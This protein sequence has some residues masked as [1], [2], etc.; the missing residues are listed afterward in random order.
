MNERAYRKFLRHRLGQ[1]SWSLM[2]YWL[3]LNASVYLI[4][5]ADLMLYR[6]RS[7]V[8]DPEVLL[9]R[10]SGNGWGY[11]LAAAVGLLILRLWKGREFCQVRLFQERH[12]MTPKNF[13]TILCVFAGGQMVF[14]LVTGILESLFNVF[15][16]SILESLNTVSTDTPSMYL[17]A[18][19][20]API[21]EELLFRGLILRTMEPFGKKYA[22]FTS[23]FLFGMFHGN[24]PQA[25]FAFA[26][27]LVL[28]YTA[29]EYS[30]GWSMA[31]HMFNNLILSDLLTRLMSPLPE[32]FANAI[33]GW[34]IL[35]LSV[36][37]LVILLKRRREIA[38]YFRR[39]R[40]DGTCVRCF[41]TAPGTVVFLILMAVNMVLLVTKL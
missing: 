17:Y 37:G 3:I 33:Q 9:E 22:I 1:S 5:M 7:G 13:L 26:V 27:G 40:M 35:L 28:G 18:G 4:G 6:L 12:I 34:V 38:A 16:L 8:S 32:M 21:T 31:L 15:G 14:Q 23:A 11:F 10:L 36:A 41:F 29:M 20:L 19:I 2:V 24:L 25:P 39:G 30:I